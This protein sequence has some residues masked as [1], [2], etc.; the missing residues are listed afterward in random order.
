MSG[1]S[2]EIAGKNLHMAMDK[3]EKG[4]PSMLP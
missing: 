2:G 1:Y 3:M 4:W